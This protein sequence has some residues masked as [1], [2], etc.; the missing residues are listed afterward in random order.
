MPRFSRS[1]WRSKGTRRSSRIHWASRSSRLTSFITCSTNSPITGKSWSSASGTRTSTSP[2]FHASWKSCR[3]WVAN[4][5]AYF[6]RVETR[7]T[8]DKQAGLRPAGVTS[9]ASILEFSEL[10]KRGSVW[11]SVRI[12]LEGS[13]RDRRDGRGWNR[14]GRNAA[15]RPEQGRELTWHFFL[16]SIPETLLHIVIYVCFFV[17]F[18][19]HY[20]MS[21]V[22]K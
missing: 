10:F 13:D 2:C 18:A 15:L 8:R 11:I 7:V 21:Y 4:A 20:R 6:A 12:Q 3:R 14:Q 22:Y 16:L 1:T 9:F 5:R 19:S 17:L